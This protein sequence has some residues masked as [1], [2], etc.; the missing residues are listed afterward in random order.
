MEKLNPD[1]AR[2]LPKFTQQVTGTPSLP[3]V[4]NAYSE[5]FLWERLGK[6]PNKPAL[7][8]SKDLARRKEKQEAPYRP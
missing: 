6:A 2:D 8:E 4:G 1:W 3:A 5:M 7:P